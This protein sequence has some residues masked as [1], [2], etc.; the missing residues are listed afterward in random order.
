[1][2]YA[3]DIAVMANSKKELK[4][5]VKMLKITCTK[6]EENINIKVDDTQLE[7]VKNFN[8]PVVTFQK[9]ETRQ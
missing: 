6:Q 3:V 9:A 5:K 7:Q 1:M 8:Y 2:R 4:E